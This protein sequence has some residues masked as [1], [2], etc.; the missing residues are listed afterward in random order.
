MKFQTR[1]LLALLLAVLML[2]MTAACA[3]E[4]GGTSG[5]KTYSARE[6]AKVAA[7]VGDKYEITKG[8]VIDTYNNLVQMYEYYGMTA[9]TEDADIETMQ[10]MAVDSLVSEKLL[11]YQAD[12]QG[13]AL[14]DE[15]LAAVEAELAETMAYWKDQF[16][17]QAESEGAENV[18]ARMVEIFNEQLA[19]SGMNMDM[20]EYEA[21][22]R[23]SMVN[24]AII[25]A[26]Q[27]KFKSG[28]TITDDEVRAYYDN[29]LATQKEAYAETPASYQSDQEAYEMN[30][31]NPVLF[32][33]EGFLRVRTITVSPAEEVSADYTALITGMDAYEAEYGK[34]LL[35]YG[36]ELLN[37]QVEKT[38]ATAEPETPAAEP[39]KGD[40]AETS[41]EEPAEGEAAEEAAATYKAINAPT[42]EMGKAAERLAEI[43]DKYNADKVEA[44]K[45]YEAYIA[46]AKAKIEEAAKALQDG[47]TFDEVLK[48]YGEDDMFITYPVFAEKG[49]LMLR[50]GETTM[51]AKLVE[52]A[53]ALEKGAFSDV[54]QVDDMFY[55]VS[56]V[57]DEPAGEKAFADVEEEIRALALA[58]KAEAAWTEQQTAWTK[59]TSMVEYIE[60]VYRDIGK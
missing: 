52:A 50:E 28:V 56:P 4:D 9:P 26:L 17:A 49:I 10:D 1:K 42:E 40:A 36:T 35:E 53:L 59:D 41:T 2:G 37:V 27:E 57:G 25:A 30:G 15:Q 11:L 19:A 60:K 51:D 54:I 6:R 16:T 21:Y 48:E 47:K 7:K 3:L 22:V 58:E 24:E 38:G 33:P 34:L 55:I 23:D 5:V 18:E 12:Q 29:L 31:G 45:L 8:D 46:D 44:D 43:V 13:V 39:A 20:T 14:T 32:A